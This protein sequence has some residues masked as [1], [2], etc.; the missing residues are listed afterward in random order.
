MSYTET[1]WFWDYLR[2]YIVDIIRER[3]REGGGEE[4]EVERESKYCLENLYLGEDEIHIY[5]QTLT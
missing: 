5:I 1:W 2:A 3:E 4:E